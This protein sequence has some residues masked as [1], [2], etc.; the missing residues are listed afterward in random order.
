MAIDDDEFVERV[1][2]ATLRQVEVTE[3]AEQTFGDAEKARE[4]L[5]RPLYELSGRTPLDVAQTDA[6]A[7]FIKTILGKIAWGAAD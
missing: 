4:W 2:H 3:L 5:L 6:G 7:R 1:V